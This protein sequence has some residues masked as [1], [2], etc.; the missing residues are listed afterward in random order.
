VPVAGVRAV[1]TGDEEAPVFLG[2]AAQMLLSTAALAADRP[3]VIDGDRSISYGELA[4]RSQAIASRLRWAGVGPGDRVAVLLQRGG[5][6][7]AAFFGVLASGAVAV[8]VNETLRPR[9]IEYILD[10]AEAAALLTSADLLDRLPRMLETTAR[11]L[12]VDDIPPRV[13]M[14]PELRVGSDVAQIIYTSGSTGLPKGVTVSHGNLWAGMHAVVHYLG[15]T[16]ADR[17]ASLLPFSFDYGLNQL[18]CSAGTGATLIVERSPIPHRILETL[19]TQDV[20]VLAAV[21]PLWL[22]LLTVKAFRDQPLPSLRVMT[23]TGGRLPVDAVRALR[24]CQPHAD[25]VLMYGLTEAFRSTYLT[26]EL[27]DQKP[28]SIGRAIPGAEILVLD[29]GLEPCG[30]GETGQLVHR[31]ATVALGYWRDPEATS[32]VFRPHPLRPP[33]APDSERVVFSGDLVYRDEDGDLFFVSREDKLI[34]TLGYRVS[35]DEVA[36]VL[37][38]S[39]E[40]VEALVVS[41]PDEVRGAVVVAFVV[42]AN[43]G[44]L[45]RLEAFCTRELPRYMQPSRIE[46]R[47]ALS[48]TPSGKHDPMATAEEALDDRS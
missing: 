24:R 20:T 23:N 21:P 31:G 43:G 9:Q 30:P 26:P 10:H 2:N 32:K 11:I 25:L 13:I 38:A 5:D 17:I 19:R 45:E 35:P 14:E 42:L 46:V 15:L 48:R 37:Y 28:G 29:E 6:A 41:E 27:A 34:K 7:A 8:T 47:S 1:P 4:A 22:Q 40:V 16:K 44:Q 3:A 12:D 36:E 33:G 39:G 18:L